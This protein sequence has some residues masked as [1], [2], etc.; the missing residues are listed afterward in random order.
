MGFGLRRDQFDYYNEVMMGNSG[1]PTPLNLECDN[2]DGIYTVYLLLRRL[3]QS[4]NVS[5]FFRTLLRDNYLHNH[6]PEIQAMVGCEE[7]PKWHPE[8]NT[9]EHTMLVLDQF[10]THMYE[11]SSL[12][13]VSKL[14]TNGKYMLFLACLYHDMG[15][16]WVKPT[17]GKVGFFPGHAQIG[18]KM[19]QGVYDRLAIDNMS[20]HRTLHDVILYHMHMHDM[21]KMKPR[22]IFKMLHRMDATSFRGNE[23]VAVLAMLGELDRLGRKG[24][25]QLEP[26]GLYDQIMKYVNVMSSCSHKTSAFDPKKQE[27]KILS[28]YM[29]TW[30]S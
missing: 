14:D 20:F 29:D 25:T 11:R 10:D 23:A 27:N 6:F 16:P 15:K 28:I 30:K 17:P 9:F 7:N 12:N 3:G 4:G 2:E 13:L 1:T 18:A 22:T 8:G 21:D 24:S 26:L 5:S 19:W